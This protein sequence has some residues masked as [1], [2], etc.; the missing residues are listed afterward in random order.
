MN[1]GAVAWGKRFTLL[2]ASKNSQKAGVHTRRS[3]FQMFVEDF[4]ELE[5][6]GLPVGA[7]S[8]PEDVDDDI[9]GLFSMEQRGTKRA[10]KRPKGPF[11]AD[12]D[13]MEDGMGDVVGEGVAEDVVGDGVAEGAEDAEVAEVAEVAEGAEGAEGAEVAEDADQ[14]FFSDLPGDG[15]RKKNPSAV[16]A[17][18]RTARQKRQEERVKTRPAID[19]DRFLRAEPPVLDAL[20]IWLALTDEERTPYEEREKAKEVEVQAAL[21]REF[22]L[23]EDS[24][25][26]TLGQ[27]R[28][29]E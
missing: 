17:R 6:A 7:A 16:E 19:L 28:V 12:D 14:S 20:T 29:G 21:N 8:S 10:G 1:H 9:A 11:L 2:Q 5:G 22:G 24:M 3:A 18:K 4:P 23:E 25:L 15:E 13:V 27:G 26:G